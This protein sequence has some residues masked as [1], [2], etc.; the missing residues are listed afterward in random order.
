MK[1]FLYVLVAVGFLSSAAAFGINA[2]MDST[3]PSLMSRDDYAS[4]RQE[5]ASE[6]RQ[7]VGRCRAMDGDARELCRA[8]ARAEERVRLAELNARYRGTFRAAE[9]AKE[10]RLRASHDIA[11]AQCAAA[12]GPARSECIAAARDERVRALAQARA[13]AT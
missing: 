9:E 3:P 13:S 11:R 8:Q 6:A 10:A 7:A 2:H 12:G 1:H 5:I 4:A